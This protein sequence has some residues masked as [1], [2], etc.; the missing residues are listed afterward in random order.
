MYCFQ[1]RGKPEEVLNEAQ[2]S[3]EVA[4]RLRARPSAPCSLHSHHGRRRHK[5]RRHPHL[6]LYCHSKHILA[7]LCHFPSTSPSR[8]LCCHRPRIHWTWRGQALSPRHPSVP[9]CLRSQGCKGLSTDPVWAFHLPKTLSNGP[10]AG[11]SI[12]LPRKSAPGVLSA[13]TAPSHFG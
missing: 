10:M 9:L 13:H 5:L 1:L 6:T 8:S 2:R 3:T 4:C 12:Q 11:P 7:P